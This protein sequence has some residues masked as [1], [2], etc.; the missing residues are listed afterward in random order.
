[1]THQDNEPHFLILGFGFNNAP[2]LIQ[3]TICIRCRLH[4]QICYHLFFT[5]S[6]QSERHPLRYQEGPGWYAQLCPILNQLSWLGHVLQVNPPRTPSS[7]FPDT[8]TSISFKSTIKRG[9]FKPSIAGQHFGSEKKSANK[10][11]INAN[12]RVDKIKSKV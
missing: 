12:Q 6:S 10:R 8:L 2:Y 5:V 4:T 9:I 7:S 11:H 3:Y 1:M